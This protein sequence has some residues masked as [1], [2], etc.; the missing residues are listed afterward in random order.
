[1]SALNQ[2]IEAYGSWRSQLA[3][4]VADYGHWLDE[5]ELSDPSLQARL[6]RI[7]ERLRDDRLSIAFV[8]EFSRG[9]SEL[10]N[11]I[12]FAQYGQR[13]VP[14]SAGRTTMCPTELSWDPAQPVGI[15]M[16][17]I[18]TRLRD[19][20]LAELRQQPGEWRQIPIEP[21]NAVSLKLAFECVRETRRVP[22]EEAILMGMY[23]E[24]DPGCVGGRDG[25]DMVEVSCWRHAIVNLPHPLLKLG[26]VL[27]D[28]PGLN[29][30]GAEPELTLNLIP[31][32][33]AVLFV[34]AADAGV[35]RS[36]IDVWRDHVSPSHGLGRFVVLNKIDGLWDELKSD[37]QIEQEIARQVQSVA[38]TLELPVERVFPVSAQKGLVAKIHEDAALLERSRLPAL[39]RALSEEIVPQRQAI[40]GDQ[41]RQEFE[42]AYALTQGVLTARR[43][44]LVEQVLELGGLRGKNRT[45]VDQ[46][47]RRIR[48]ERTEFEQTLRRLQ[49]MRS[50]FTRHS[51]ALFAQIGIDNL[52]RHVR[53]ARQAMAASKTSLGLREAMEAL[54]AA[55][56]R[57]FAEAGKLV[58]EVMTMMTAMYQTF[59]REHG[60][61]LGAPLVF[62]MRRYEAELARIEA[63]QRRHFGALSLVTTEQWALMRRFFE[64]VGVRLKSV[65]DA[66][67]RDADGWLRALM[68]PIEGQ[69]REHQAQLR[70][71]LDSV[72]RIIDA[73]E[74]L[75]SRIAELEEARALIDQQLD[76]LAALAARIN[77]V[78]DGRSQA[79]DLLAA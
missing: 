74:D 32:A 61:A 14:S 77:G 71:R 19:V 68:S 47:A 73:S 49:A 36:D 76:A 78:L 18:E 41:V 69:V 6:A 15:R 44:N 53:D 40:V 48:N 7:R 75:D 60:L 5:A 33:H 55:A 21:D 8:A 27:I 4:A 62:S 38:Q 64:S 52:K 20:S 34:L 45:V 2:R 31:G 11:A 16:L 70:R 63:L 50:V 9:K 23:D 66:A 39:E 35:T 29:A 26:L 3:E 56:Q 67:N 43:R 22:I 58:S 54:I 51:N 25:D 59:H 65:Y 28:T 79:A 17:P 1:M 42:E 24:S 46:M 72:Q 10:I 37:E 57:D 13:I 30:L 12:F